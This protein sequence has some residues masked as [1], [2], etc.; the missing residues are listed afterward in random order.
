MHVLFKT[1][2]VPIF[3]REHDGEKAACTASITKGSFS[4]LGFRLH[5][6]IRGSFRSA[7]LYLAAGA[8]Q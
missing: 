8:E 6:S 7:T 5:S 4:H 1:L 3:L 2:S